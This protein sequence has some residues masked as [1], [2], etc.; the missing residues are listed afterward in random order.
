MVRTSGRNMARQGILISLVLLLLVSITSSSVLAQAPV[1]TQPSS[2]NSTMYLWGDSSLAN[3]DCMAHF[4]SDDSTDVGYGEFDE[5]E[6]I[7]FSCSLDQPL[8]EDMYLDPEG[9]IN[10]QLGF[11]IQSSEN[12]GGDELLV[13][14]RKDSEI[15][16]QQEFTFSTYSDEQISWQ[17][18][19]TENMTFWE[20]G[21][22]PQ[23]NIQ[24]N[25]PGPTALECLNPQKALAGCDSKFRLYYSDNSEGLNVE[26][27]FPIINA[28]DPAAVNP[29]DSQNDDEAVAMSVGSGS[30]SALLF[31]PWFIGLFAFVGF[32]TLQRDRFQLGMVL[33]DES[34]EA[35]SGNSSSDGNTL[36]DSYRARVLT[37]CALYVAQGIPWGF[38]TI[39]FLTFLADKGVGAGELALML[40]LGTLPWS[41][42]FLWGPVIDR[43]QFPSLGRRRPWILFAQSGMILVLASMM[44]VSNPEENVRTIAWMFFVY[45][46]FTS[47]QD[48]S[49]DALAVDVLKPHEMEKVN[50]YMFTAKS[51]GG[52]IGGAGLGLIIGTLGIKATI[53]LQIPILVMIMLVPLYMTER[54]GEKRFP[55]SEGQGGEQLS[56]EQRDFKDILSKLKIAFSLRSAKLGIVLSLVM[57][58]SFFLIPI[59]PLLFVRELGWTVEQFNV[60]NGGIILLFTIL[61][62]LVGGQLGR[63]F[64]GKSVIIYS[65]L[66]TAVITSLWGMTESMWSNGSYMMIM[67]SIRTFTWGLVTI[68]IYSLVMRVTWSEVGGTQFTAYMAMMNV[69][70]IIGYQLTEPLASRFDYP[71]LFLIAGIFETLIIFGALF[72]DPG[73]TRRTLVH[74]SDPIRE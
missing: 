41:V 47:L 69:S 33:E 10:L 58:M 73:E 36:V 37:L 2:E 60:T 52:I 5:T 55:W 34:D 48:V 17:I 50:S 6:N 39:A 22:T 8:L 12:S 67:W 53:L 14:L 70:S 30:L 25:K 16:A 45:N 57:S 62:Y 49:T 74:H 4:S 31:S 64:G 26:G 23:L 1:D 7:D 44:L 29:N 40:T 68:N 18:E 24:F 71:T 43:F 11:M 35:I 32:V 3:G 61:G 63:R 66:F 28:S 21:V 15:L 38:I 27:T 59:L 56:D 72:I 46:I 20:E 13:S 9:S 54:P 19:I 42:K 65:A 51:I